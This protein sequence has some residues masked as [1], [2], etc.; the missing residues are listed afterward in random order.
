[1]HCVLDTVLFSPGDPTSSSPAEKLVPPENDSASHSASCDATKELPLREGV[2]SLPCQPDD[3]TINVLCEVLKILFN[4][5]VD[6]NEEEL[7]EVW[8]AVSRLIG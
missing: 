8:P 6:W 3:R 7:E 5:T 1:M 4:Q 2:V